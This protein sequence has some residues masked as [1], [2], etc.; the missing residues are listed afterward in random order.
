MSHLVMQFL[1][2]QTAV[3]GQYFR[4]TT[5]CVGGFQENDSYQHKQMLPRVHN[6]CACSVLCNTKQGLKYSR[7]LKLNCVRTNE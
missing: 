2:L 7:V 6:L 3:S 5:L 4:Q 1:R